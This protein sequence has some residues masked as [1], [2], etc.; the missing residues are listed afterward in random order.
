VPGGLLDRI[1]LG[2]Y[3]R[4]RRLTRQLRDLDRWYDAQRHPAARPRRPGRRRGHGRPVLVALG[5]LAITLPACLFGLRQQ[6]VYVDWSALAGLVGGQPA[7]AAGGP[8][9]TGYAFLAHQ[10]GS[11]GTP[12]TYDSC[13]PLH[14]V[15]NDR[16][17][18]TG[19]DGLLQSAVDEVSTASGLRIVVDGPTDE[20][21]SRARPL[22]DPARYGSRWS[23][24]L[25]AWTTPHQVPGLR[26][27]VVG[28][29]GSASVSTP[30]GRRHYVTGT[31]SLDTPGLQ[32]VLARSPGRGTLEVR[33]VMMHELGHVLGLAHVHDRGQIMFARNIGRTAWGA[34]DR[35]GLARLGA[36]PC[37]G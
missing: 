35:A 1:V 37:L 14:V 3:R 9:G 19:T 28:L 32:R 29:G 11:P 20:P 15:V 34:G 33:A 16:L 6:G 26:G 25:V 30:G 23:P 36:G 31:V 4:R 24:V 17:A 21:P 7:A 12:V 8:A 22:R 27:K 10:P 13:A 5:T 2:P 18:P